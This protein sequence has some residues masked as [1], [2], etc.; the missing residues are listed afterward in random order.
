MNNDFSIQRR[1]IPAFLHILPLVTMG[2]LGVFS[3]AE[4]AKDEEPQAGDRVAEVRFEGLSI[5]SPDEIRFYVRTVE[6]SSFS[7]LRLREDIFALLRAS[8]R[9]I[10]DVVVEAEEGEEGWIL[11]FQLKEKPQIKT[12]S[13]DGIRKKGKK[14]V[15]EQL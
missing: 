8:N 3:F 12:I 10:E 1:S 11:I 13:L 2:V 9:A 5:L 14:D 15:L 6:G 4:A 7:P